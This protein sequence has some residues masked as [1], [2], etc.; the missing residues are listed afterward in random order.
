MQYLDVFLELPSNPTREISP[1]FLKSHV[2]KQLKQLFGE[3]GSSCEIDILKYT[4][5]TRSLIIR[6]R[7]EDYVRLRSSLTLASAYEEDLCVYTITKSSSSPFGL[8]S[9][10]R[11]YSH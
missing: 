1:I 11:G 6:C 5:K 2:T 9:N 4:S 10:G 8:L 7:D 3:K